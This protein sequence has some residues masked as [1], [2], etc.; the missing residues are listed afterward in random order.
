MKLT[1][2]R[3]K[4]LKITTG[5]PSGEPDPFQCD[6]QEEKRDWFVKGTTNITQT[7]LEQNARPDRPPRGKGGPDDK[8]PMEM[9]MVMV[10]PIEMVIQ[11]VM[12]IQMGVEI[13]MEMKNHPE[14]GKNPLE[15]MENQVKVVGDQTPVMMMGWRW[16]LLSFKCYTI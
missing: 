3:K 12:V 10:A 16:V 9:G 8:A 6:P 4:P 14:E 1:F 11:M 13:Q 5:T 15:E 2:S 7:E